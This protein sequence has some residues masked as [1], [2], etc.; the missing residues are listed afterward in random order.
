MA[1][2]IRAKTKVADNDRWLTQH[3]EELV[4]KHAGE[5]IVVADGQIYRSGTP[6]QLRDRARA[7]HPR[8]KI[9]GLRIPRPEDFLCAL[10]IL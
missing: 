9:M 8:A 1:K 3:F 4:D 7:E 5:F 10:I 6:S 2:I